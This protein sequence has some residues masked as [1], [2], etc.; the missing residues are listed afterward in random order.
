MSLM[1]R[2]AGRKPPTGPREPRNTP[3][4][5]PGAP[6]PVVVEEPE[7]ISPNTGT[8]VRG[9]VT[10][11]F[12]LSAVDQLKVD[13]HHKLVS[14]LDLEALERIRDETEIMAQI[15]LAVSDFLRGEATPLSQGEREEIVESIVWEITG[16][17]PIEPL[18]RDKQITDILVNNAKDIFIE[19]RGKLT[20]YPAQF[21]NDAH[22]LAIIDRIVSRVGRRVDESSP[23]VD[24]RLPDGSRVNAIIPPLALDGPVLSIRRFGKEISIKQ[25]VDYGSMTPEMVQLLSGCV[26]ARLNILISGGTGSGK[27]TLLNGLSSFIPSDERVVTIEDAAE[28][29]LQQEHVVRLETRPPNSEGRGEVVARDLVKNALRM[30]PDRIVIGEV[31][32]AEA[33]DMLQAMNTGHEGSLSTVHANSPRDA[34]SRLEVM[35]LMAGTNLPNRAMREQV[36][37]ALDLVVQVQRLS[38]GGRR[39]TSVVEVTGM[40]GEV[41][42]T[43]EIFRYRRKG[44]TPE[45]KIVG[46]FEATG[47]RP[48]FAEKLLVSGIEL[49]RGLFE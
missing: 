18:F 20:R 9:S 30:R 27:T 45:G 36:A 38:D 42:T 15:R 14:R 6:A 33:L 24:A 31:R 32:G 34:L 35:I 25:L 26:R 43:Q 40:E 17:G 19:K 16:L 8:F 47:I 28:L 7:P 12:E 13:I 37:S 11:T 29:R 21:R 4:P 2:L 22:L 44:V 46:Q 1:D 41:V 39:V 49:P 23:M 5:A 3:V 48:L 10:E